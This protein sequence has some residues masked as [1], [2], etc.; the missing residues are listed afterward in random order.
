MLD[1]ALIIIQVLLKSHTLMGESPEQL[2]ASVPYSDF[3]KAMLH[4]LERLSAELEQDTRN[5]L[6][7]YAR[8]RSTLDPCALIKLA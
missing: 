4:D 1:L 5:V 3:T 7:T 2:L 6:L 8:I